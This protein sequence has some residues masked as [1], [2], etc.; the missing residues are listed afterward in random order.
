M[1]QIVQEF[2]DDVDDAADTR[3]ESLAAH[4]V[5]ND[6]KSL[7]NTDGENLHSLVSKALYMAKRGRPLC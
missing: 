6:R 5:D 3:A 7:S 1:G 2:L 4:H